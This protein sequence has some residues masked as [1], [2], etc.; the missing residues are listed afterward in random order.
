M[1]A[2]KNTINSKKK[3][4]LSKL[5]LL[6]LAGVAALAIS[7]GGDDLKRT[8]DPEALYNFRT[9]INKI[10]PPENDITH[11]DSWYMPK[12]NQHFVC[13]RGE[14]IIYGSHNPKNYTTARQNVGEKCYDFV[15]PIEITRN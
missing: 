9:T 12:V 4:S 6:P 15:G 5:I 14:Y 3:M 1:K 2:I 13:F 11:F 7:C 8:N 10:L